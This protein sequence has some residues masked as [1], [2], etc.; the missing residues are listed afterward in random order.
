MRDTPEARRLCVYLRLV[1]LPLR[2]LGLFSSSIE[3]SI[4]NT[5]RPFHVYINH[6]VNLGDSSSE[7]RV[8]FLDVARPNL[9]NVV[10]TES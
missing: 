3:F 1:R 7:S 8:C 4:L 9:S 5:G 10:T 6:E 2:L